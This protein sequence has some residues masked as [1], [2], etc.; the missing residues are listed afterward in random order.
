MRRGGL[1]AHPTPEALAVFSAADLPPEQAELFPAPLR[2]GG[3]VFWL[4][5]AGSAAVRAV[6]DAV[7]EPPMAD[8]LVAGGLMVAR[9]LSRVIADSPTLRAQTRCDRGPGPTN[10]ISTGFHTGDPVAARPAFAE[11]ADPK[12][13]EPCLD[14]LR[15]ARVC[16]DGVPSTMPL[17]THPPQRARALGDG[18]FALDPGARQQGPGEGP[19]EGAAAVAHRS[20]P[21]GLRRIEGLHGPDRAET[22][23]RRPSRPRRGPRAAS[24]AARPRR[25]GG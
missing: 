5:N 23:R 7:P 19:G 16:I 6:F 2:D 17:T 15:R 3:Q 21:V 11:V 1:P 10:V 18:W 25:T 4:A 9:R 13:L 12:P 14:E 20:A 22:V 8:T 24:H